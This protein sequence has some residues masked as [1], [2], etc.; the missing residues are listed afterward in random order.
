MPIKAG[1]DE[2]R[3]IRWRRAG[4]GCQ[5]RVP[6]DFSGSF[7]RQETQKCQHAPGFGAADPGAECLI[8]GVAKGPAIWQIPAVNVSKAVIIAAGMNQGMLPLQPPVD[9][10]EV[11]ALFVELL[12]QSHS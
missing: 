5:W 4:G 3:C 9:R 6:V 8:V 10:D 12:V 7:P 11:L 2:V 1:R